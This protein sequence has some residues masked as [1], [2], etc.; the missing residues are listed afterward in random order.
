MHNEK[1]KLSNKE[2]LD[3]KINSTDWTPTTMSNI[4]KVV[5]FW[6]EE[7]AFDIVIGHVNEEKIIATSD[8]LVLIICSDKL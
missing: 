4:G 2:K 6:K 7:V 1:Q 3:V 5:K 8:M